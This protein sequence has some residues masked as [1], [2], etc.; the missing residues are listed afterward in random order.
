MERV[1]EVIAVAVFRSNNQTDAVGRLGTFSS[2]EKAEAFVSSRRDNETAFQDAFID[3][4][5]DEVEVK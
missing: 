1:Y 2:R 4:R 5:V 3:Y